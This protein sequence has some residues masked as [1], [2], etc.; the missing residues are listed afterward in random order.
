MDSNFR[1]MYD[2]LTSTCTRFHRNWMENM[3]RRKDVSSSHHGEAITYKR[4]QVGNINFP[5]KRR[6]SFDPGILRSISRARLRYVIAAK[7]KPRRPISEMTT[8]EVHELFAKLLRDKQE[9]RY[10]E[11]SQSAERDRERHRQRQG[12]YSYVFRSWSACQLVGI[13]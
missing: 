2:L 6:W 3:N 1:T 8:T 11:G 12:E 4:D 5:R 13:I 7:V 10:S 9:T